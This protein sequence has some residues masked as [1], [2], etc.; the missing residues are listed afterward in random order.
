MDL[1]GAAKGGQMKGFGYGFMMLW[2]A[3]V[4]LPVQAQNA[5][6]LTQSIT[7]LSGVV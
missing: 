1:I 7:S 6:P 5:G 2:L 3:A 4:S